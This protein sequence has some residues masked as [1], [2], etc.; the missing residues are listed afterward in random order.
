MIKRIKYK[1]IDFVKYSTCL[2][3]SVQRK[4]SAT[5]DFLD[6]SSNKNWEILVYKD[7]EA[8]MPVPFVIKFG[9]KFVHNPMLCQQLG[10][11]SAHD[12]VVV[13]DLFIKYLHENYLVKVYNFNDTNKF[14]LDLKLRKNFIIYPDR[15]ENVYAKYSPKRKRKLRA[16]EDVLAKT[17][18]KEISYLEGKEFI[19][20]N[21][22]GANKEKNIRL[23]ME[24]FNRMYKANLTQFSAFYFE[25]TLTN[26][27]VTYQDKKTIA[28]LGTF[29]DKNYVKLSGA[30]LLIDDIIKKNITTKS[31]DFE[32]SEL[33]NVE[34]FFRGFRPELKPYPTIVFSTKELVKSIITLKFIGRY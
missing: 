22:L 34:E 17:R 12:S 10:I 30:S 28:L 9:I 33:P 23:F 15:Y 32:G 1:D 5:K 13:N 24:I 19:Q 18:I 26:I 25:N 11:F 21:I 7:Y 16:D 29:N 8:I 20:A 27:I 6:I 31:F 2:E 14:S 4:Y 3:N